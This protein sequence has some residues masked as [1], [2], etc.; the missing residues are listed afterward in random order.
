MEEKQRH[1]ACQLLGKYQK[2]QADLSAFDKFIVLADASRPGNIAVSTE[3]DVD[4]IFEWLKTEPDIKQVS[5]V[6]LWKDKLSGGRISRY[7]V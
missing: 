5:F 4:N 3:E 2:Y 7:D 1:F 6:I